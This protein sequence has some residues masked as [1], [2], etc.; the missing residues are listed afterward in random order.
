[1][2]LIDGGTLEDWLEGERR[3][4]REIVAAFLAAG[5]GLAAAHGAGLVHRD[6]KPRNVL[7]AKTGRIVVTDFGLVVGIEAGPDIALDATGRI[8]QVKLDASPTSSNLSGL[9]VTG[10]V[11]GTPAY[12]APE[13]WSGASVGPPADQ[14]AFCVALWEA[15]AGKRP[16]QGTT[17]ETLRAAIEKGPAAL[18]DSKIPRRFRALLRRGLD[19]DPENRWPSMTE[20]LAALSRAERGPGV[21]LAI[22]A[23]AILAI[24]VGAW[25]F[26]RSSDGPACE[27]PVMAPSVAW[28][29]VTGSLVAQPVMV[30]AIDADLRTWKAVRERTCT[31]DEATRQAQLACLDGVL[32][33]IDALRQAMIAVGGSTRLQASEWMIDPAVCEA[34]RPPRLARASSAVFVDVVAAQLRASAT[35]VPVEESDA[36]NL[37]ARAGAEPCATAAARLLVAETRDEKVLQN[38]DFEEAERAAQRCGDDWLLARI[39]LVS[40][41]WI[42]SQ[43]AIDVRTQTKVRRAETAVEAIPLHDLQGQL[44][45]VHARVAHRADDL[46]EAIARAEAAMQHYVARGRLGA[47]IAAGLEM[48][49]YRHLRARPDDLATIP[50]TLE[51]WRAEAAAQLGGSDP[52]VVELDEQRAWTKFGRGDVAAAHALLGSLPPSP[53]IEHPVRITGRVVDDQGVPVAGA[54]VAA[55]AYLVGDTLGAWIPDPGI[56]T[57]TTGPDGRFSIPEAP[58]EGVVIAQLGSARSRPMAVA[59]DVTLALAPTSRLEGTVDLRGEPP[60]A[61]TIMVRDATQPL[62]LPYYGLR[63]PVLPDGSFVIDGMPRVK[64]LVQTHV[65]RATAAL[66]AGQEVTIGKPVETM[67]LSVQVSKRVIHVIVRSTISQ[68]ISNGQVVVMPGNVPSTNLDALATKLQNASVKNLRPILGEN[69]PPA[70]I[71]RAKPGDLYVTMPAVPEG[72]ISACAVGFPP[73]EQMDE[74]LGKQ[75]EKPENRVRVLMPCVLLG[76]TDDV[77]VIEVPPWPRFD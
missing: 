42:L 5:R 27:A 34:P 29:A 51:D 21:V 6:F 25:L 12:M 56:R 67:Q 11:L 33:R 68:P 49:G 24:A 65:S 8:S 55:G 16:F 60:A 50:A 59:A 54:S 9:T 40:S 30:A 48:L 57:A 61:V 28:P 36:E 18:D 14:F 70:V 15:L 19:P 53:R 44:E 74:A 64:V 69:A 73:A 45:L 26:A 35:R 38:A 62:T 31:L 43:G 17:L 23:A 1:M 10:A 46:D 52:L 63:A 22:G 71:G 77:A 41:R 3:T 2:E 66:L 76:P 75:L 39:A 4:T 58:E 37:L 13:Q 72:Q 20:L 32:V 47:R 7:R